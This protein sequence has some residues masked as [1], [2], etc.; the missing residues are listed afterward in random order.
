MSTEEGLAIRRERE[1]RRRTEETPEN[2]Q[3]RLDTQRTCDE[4]GELKRPPRT[5]IED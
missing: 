4:V 3:R 2:R 5:G 1:K